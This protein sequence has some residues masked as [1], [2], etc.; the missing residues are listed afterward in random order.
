MK[1]NIVAIMLVIM[2]GLVQILN[3]EAKFKLSCAEKCGLECLGSEVYA[4]CFAECMVKCNTGSTSAKKCI[5]NCGVNK[6]ITV[7]IGIYFLTFL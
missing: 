7:N 1:T 2:L 5:M 6:S 4:V 3:I